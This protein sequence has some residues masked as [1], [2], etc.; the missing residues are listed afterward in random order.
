MAKT[1]EQ[2]YAYLADE[3]DARVCTD[4]SDDACRVVP[5]N[6]FR[7]LLAQVCTKL[8]DALANTKTVLPWVMNSVGAPTF[9]SGLLVPVRESG[10]L[11]PQLFL[12]GVIRRYPIRKW[13]FVL[14]CV[15][16]AVAVLCMAA[17]AFGM[18]GW[19]AGTAIIALLVLFSLARGFCSIASKDVLGKTIPK[20]RRGRLSGYSASVVGLMTIAVGMAVMLNL[21][22]QSGYYWLL[23]AAGGLC[24]VVAAMVFSGTDE[25]K[26]ATEGGGNALREAWKSL[27]LLKTDMYFRRFVLV[28]C[29]MMSSGLSAPYIILLANQSDSSAMSGLGLFIVAS[30]VAGLISGSVWGKFAD[31]SSRKVIIL[32][33]TLAFV[34][35]AL[36]ATI[37]YLEQGNYW[38][39]LSLFFLLAVTHEGVRLGR[40]TYVVDLA[41]G[42]KRTDYVA[43]SNTFI[44]IMLL[45]VGLLGAA[46]AQVSLVYV[47][48]VFALASASATCLGVAL[49]EVQ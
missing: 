8:G 31:R 20:S 9:L 7:I 5:G 28:R 27:S 10:S 46:I 24:W 25:Y 11:I 23:L 17:V 33:A 34:I 1:I 43:V 35:C 44:G 36:T 42:N 18:T 13:F 14:G 3:E 21:R 39:Y 16:Q 41:Q 6:F 22:E 45:V 29:L 38:L 48:G 32:T 12:G 15:L 37:A 19:Q 2:L 40:K 49:K 4:I 26:G 30:G 47:L